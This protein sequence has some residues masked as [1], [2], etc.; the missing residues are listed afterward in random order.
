[1]ELCLLYVIDY[2]GD[3]F[4]LYEIVYFC[5]CFCDFLLGLYGFVLYIFVIKFRSVLFVFLCNLLF[6]DIENLFDFV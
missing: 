1:M 5:F 4:L 3:V 2:F 6:F